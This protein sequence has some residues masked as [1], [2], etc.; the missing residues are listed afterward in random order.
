M[1]A[2]I[3][4][5]KGLMNRILIIKLGSIG[6]VVHTLPALSDLRTSFPRARIDW[7]VEKQAAVLLRNH[8]WLDRVI[9]VDTREWR[10]APWRP[11]TWREIYRCRSRMKQQRYELA[12]DFQGLW[13]SAAFGFFS[14]SGLLV[15]FD[16]AHLKEPACRILYGKRV[17]PDPATPHVSDL[18]RGL[19]ASQGA[20]RGQ[21]GFGLGVEESDRA[22]VEAQLAQHRLKEFII[23][24]PGGGWATK[25]WSPSNYGLLHHR[26]GRHLGLKTVLTWG[27]GEEGLVRKVM[28]ACPG[29]KPSTF[30][31]T[32]P[33]FIALARRSRLFVGGDTGP[34]HLAAA[35]RTPVVA[36]F[37]PT[38]PRR[39]GSPHPEDLAVFHPVP[40]GPCHK[41]VRRKY[42]CRCITLVPV[43]QVFDAVVKRLEHPPAQASLPLRAG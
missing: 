14:G 29:E 9:A 40:C 6:D 41:G 43:D 22:Y 11:R 25:N 18:H 23:L 42:G 31:T 15:G 32:L 8:P 33:Q 38:D 27:P 37:G 21:G 5:G 20:V 3:F 2:S 26:I 34:M 17:S 7:V 10:R 24:N 19:V 13:K 30:A 35:C 28:A 12:F 39:N 36:I 16:R 1:A 4:R